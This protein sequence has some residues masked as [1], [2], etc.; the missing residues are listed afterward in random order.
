[1]AEKYLEGSGEI[2]EYEQNIFYE[3][4]QNRKIRLL[5]ELIVP[6]KLTYS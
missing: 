3:I 2:R 1:M 6:D 5:Y 4:F